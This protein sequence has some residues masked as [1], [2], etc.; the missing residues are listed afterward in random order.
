MDVQDRPLPKLI[1]VFL[2]V[3]FLIGTTTFP[4]FSA[5]PTE[6]TGSSDTAEFPY[7]GDDWAWSMVGTQY[8]HQLG[9]Y[10]DD[11]VVAVLD[12]GIDYTHPDLEDKMWDDIGYDFVE[13]DDDPMDEHGHGTHVAGIIAS[14]A[15]GAE[16]MALRVIEETGGDW[17]DVSRAVEYARDNGADIISMSF[18]GQYS[19]FT[20]AFELQMERA[21]NWDDILH[22]AAAGN[23]DSD[24]K[25]YPAGYDSVISVSAID[26]D[27]EKAYYSNHGDWIE[28]TAPG[29]GSL[30][31]V[32]STLPDESYGEKIGTSMACPF[33]TGV[34]ALRRSLKPEESNDE[35]RE[36]L[37]QTAIDLGNEE[38]YGH[39]LVNA[40]RVAG[41]EVPTPVQDLDADPDDSRVEL[42]WEEPWHHGASSIDGFRVYR[43]EYGEEMEMIEDVDPDQYDYEDLEV[44]NEITYQYSVTAYNDHGEGMESEI[45]QATPRE[46]PVSPSSPRDLEAELLDDGV[47]LTWEEPLDDGGSSV[48]YYNIY[49]EVE[50][51]EMERLDQVDSDTRDHTD[52]DIELGK[53]YTYA[54]TAENEI[55]ESEKSDTVSVLVPED[56]GPSPPR[57]VSAVVVDN[58][59]E[60]TWNSPEDDSSI[61]YYNIYRKVTEDEVFEWMGEVTG[62]TTTY[63]DKT[64]SPGTEYT[65][66]VT[67]ESDIGE[68]KMSY[69]DP[70]SVPEDHDP[71]PT[72]PSSPDEV[73]A[74]L[75][76]EG[77]EVTWDEPTDDGG[78]SI[79]AYR[80][81]RKENCGEFD[82]IGETDSGTFRYVDDE[83]SPGS[84]YTY[85]VTA[86]NEIGES[87][88]AH[89]SPVS[90]PEDH[91]PIPGEEDEGFF[92][93]I[94]ESD[95]P[96][97]P[98][99]IVG[100]GF[101]IFVVVALTKRSKSQR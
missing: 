17:V 64:V 1:I 33:V 52:Q 92:D 32:F 31:Q 91:T 40:Y 36:F 19:A 44:E 47:E 28:M 65:Y 73:S 59:V 4:F 62:E 63:L 50:D 29:G 55:G 41:G 37:Q 77:V 69:S 8:A 97:I 95:L 71:S 98:L 11:V 94:T 88:R 6:I 49:R 58:G 89:T 85:A 83:I 96:I 18:G 35:V 23:D 14:V 22:I 12:T 42:R 45:V 93:W 78:S 56:H 70:I 80:I 3:L 72:E 13:N 84:E 26:S 67:S 75:L 87:E 24:E 66:A 81:Y 90:I 16:L 38:Y 46:E 51:N 100:V 76:D 39:G 54:I 30:D 7:P 43:A 5:D 10:G 79:T 57:D 101:L 68:S 9:K 74:E 86:Q 15:P 99:L 61:V 60:V 25:Y 82:L 21:Y 2:I 48:T 34:A 20:P 27:K 53:E